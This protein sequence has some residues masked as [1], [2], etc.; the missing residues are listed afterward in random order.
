MYNV[1]RRDRSQD[2]NGANSNHGGDLIAISKEFIS[3]EI[4]EF[5]KRMMGQTN[6]Y[7]QG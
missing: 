7:D 3:S 5:R 2:G 4:K 1:Y 6:Q